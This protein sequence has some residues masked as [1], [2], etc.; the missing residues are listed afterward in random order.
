M[1][2]ARELRKVSAELARIAS[3]LDSRPEPVLRIDGGPALRPHT[4][5]GWWQLWSGH[6]CIALLRPEDV[7]PLTKGPAS[8]RDESR[9]AL[10]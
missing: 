8:K 2:P 10:K 4:I 7:A 1:S 5:K 3:D 9:K 6:I